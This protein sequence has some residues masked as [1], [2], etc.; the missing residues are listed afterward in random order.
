[1]KILLVED[2]PTLRYA[3]SALIRAA[4]HEPVIAE[5]GEQAL[6]VV[7]KMPVDMIIMDVEMPG[8]DGFETTR[9]I[10]EWLGEHWIPIIFVTGLSEDENLREGIEAG[11]DDYLIK[12]V[13]QVILNA[14]IR[15][16][17]RILA[18]RDQMN[19]L[20]HELTLLS[21]RDSLTQLY[22]RRTFD[23]KAEEA[24]RIATR[25]KAP[26]TLILLD[27]DHFKQY[28]DEYGHSAGDT[29]I[30]HIAT[31][32]KRCLHRPSDVVARYG[33]EEFIAILPGTPKEGAHFVA[34]RIRKTIEALNIKHRGSLTSEKVTASVG[35][36]VTNYTTGTTLFDQINKA[37]EALYKA[38]ENGRNTVQLINSE[39]AT[40]ILVVDDDTAT[41][42]LIS[43][44]LIGHSQIATAQTG[45]KC[46][47]LAGDLQP[48]VILLD[49][50]LPGV[51]GFELC[52]SLRTNPATAT[53]P[54]IV[55][56]E[57]KKD[58]LLDFAKRVKAN[59]CLQKPLNL[60]RLL[61]KITPFLH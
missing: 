26:I 19:K 4:G 50:Y 49:L 21:Q 27:I 24:W 13:S 56:S 41:L 53:I 15:A 51:N 40:K 54:I 25:N 52:Q 60:D 38:K 48:D 30:R 16:M 42:N 57:S 10:R 43:K 17:E 12:P 11:G 23:E 47:S 1:M 18:M 3:T 28:N 31:A 7:D 36:S 61:A 29:V 22:N 46:I 5:S 55:M 37:D 58:E 20:N 59:G 33:G 32:L 35:V 39:P 44:T 34:E 45:E 14:K 8:L 2:S 9:L 6:Q